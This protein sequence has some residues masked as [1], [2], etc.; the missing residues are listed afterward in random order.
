MKQDL[1][2]TVVA[3]A[4]NEGQYISEW[5][6]HNLAIGFDKIVIYIN[7]STDDMLHIVQ[8]IEKKYENISHIIWPSV[9]GISPQVSAYNSAITAVDTEW[10]CFL[11]IDEFLVPFGYGDLKGFLKIIPDDVSSVHINWRNFGS[12]GR[13]EPNYESV[14]DAFTRCAPQ[15]WGNHFHYK[16]IARTAL[17][18]DVHIHDTAMKSGRRTLSDFDVFEMQYRGIANRVAYNGV[19]INHYQSKTYPEFCSRMQRGDANFALSAPRE[20]SR[21]RFEI[22]D[23]N[24]EE[25][26]NISLVRNNFWHIY[27][28]IKNIIES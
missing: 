14:T 8:K 18:E 22:L 17:I 6:A 23:R 19:Q 11:D 9:V 24:E 25:D 12:S 16:S 4:K 13:T 21:E 2:A 5:I 7:D 27:S 10:V 20:H 28:E 1:S 3:I 15:Q 26:L